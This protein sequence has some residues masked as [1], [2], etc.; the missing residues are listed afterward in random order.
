MDNYNRIIKSISICKSDMKVSPMTNE[1]A[2]SL[3]NEIVSKINNKKEIRENRYESSKYYIYIGEFPQRHVAIDNR[4]GTSRLFSFYCYQ[5][6]LEQKAN[7]IFAS[8]KF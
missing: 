8:P 7:I 4:A 3:L 1:E 5:D 2:I 6:Y